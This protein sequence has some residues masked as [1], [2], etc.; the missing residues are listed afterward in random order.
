[1]A[2]HNMYERLYSKIIA[3]EAY[4]CRVRNIVEDTKFISFIFCA[5]LCWV[6]RASPI[7]FL[8]LPHLLYSLS[9]WWSST[10]Q[11]FS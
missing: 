2:C 8:L 9:M 6:L 3:G 5:R 10:P 1:M 4:Y 11:V 7:K